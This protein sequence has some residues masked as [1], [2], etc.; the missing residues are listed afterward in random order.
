MTARRDLW[1]IGG[2][3][4]VI[5]L[6]SLVTIRAVTTLLSPEEYGQLSLL[7]V[8]QTFCGLFLINPVGQHINRHT[9]QW[10]DDV[11][12]LS[13]LVGYRKYV[14][15]ISIIG[16]IAA[17][18]VSMQFSILHISIIVLTMILMVNG[19]T[20]NAT[21]IPLLNMVG[22]RGTAVSWTIVTSII[23]LLVSVFL[24]TIWPTAIAWFIGQASG[25]TLGAI[26]AGLAIRRC[27]PPQKIIS[28]YSLL[29]WQVILTYCLPLAAGTGF[30]WIQLS[31]Y[32]LLVEHYWGLSL[33][34]FLSVGLSLAG[35]IWGLTETLAQQFL[36][37]LFYKRITQSGN[38]SSSAALSDLMN[39]MMPIYLV[40]V[41]MTFLGAPYLLK[42]LVAPKY[43]SAE[44]FMRLGIGI[45]FCRVVANLLSN[46]A[47]VTK[48][49]R[50]IVL[51]YAT[52]AVIAILMLV[53]VGERHLDAT[54]IAISLL[55]A[56]LA[57]LVVMWIA[58][59]REIRFVP[60][61][62]RWLAAVTVMLVLL[63]PTYWLKQPTDWVEVVVALLV[64]G[65]LG[66][67]AIV[68][69][70]RTN[71]ALQRLAMVDLKSGNGRT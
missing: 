10:W 57:M 4:L 16:G 48:Q 45:E 40:L 11:S 8:I 34:G 67:V 22:R 15:A 32:R 59:F 33:L 27:V 47:Q 14:L 60:D 24:C 44:V 61:I 2:G 5:V 31:G 38:D 66:G 68:G 54:W 58:M 3:R 36:F 26:G 53:I 7:I 9:H 42:L 65:L 23:G 13:R 25:F 29:N 70:L 55:L 62:R 71:V 6:L 12:L 30:M 21:W 69:L 35:Q 19:G 43:A 28:P 64:I 1:I 56:A 39:V 18:A 49:T 41:G 50:S 17:I 46:A 51:P 52:G 20:W 37:P 63:L